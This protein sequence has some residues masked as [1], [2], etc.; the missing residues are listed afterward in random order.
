MDPL[1]LDTTNFPFHKNCFSVLPSP[2]TFGLGSS[3]TSLSTDYTS[4][5]FDYDI[6][7]SYDYAYDPPSPANS[8]PS[9]TSGSSPSVTTSGSDR[10][11]SPASSVH[12]TP[13]ASPLVMD[14]KPLV[15]HGGDH[16]QFDNG[17]INFG[18]EEATAAHAF[19]E[20]MDF[21]RSTLDLDSLSSLAR[22]SD[23]DMYRPSDG[24]MYQHHAQTTSTQPVHLYSQLP[25][26][27]P[28]PA[29]FGNSAIYL[30]PPQVAEPQHSYY[31]QSN[32]VYLGSE[33]QAQQVLQQPQPAVPL[34]YVPA[35]APVQ[36]SAQLININGMTYAVAMPVA[37]PAP[38]AIETPHG[39]YYFVPNAQPQPQAQ[40]PVMSSSVASESFVLSSGL[41]A[42]VAASIPG[43]SPLS[44]PAP[45]PQP[46]PRSVV[47]SSA[48]PHDEATPV[49]SD[50]KI[51]LPVGQGKR[52][53]TKRQPKKDQV[54]RFVC[55]FSGCGRGFARNFNMQSHYKSHLGV[56]EFNCSHCPKKFSRRH[57][58]ARHC[59]AVHDSHVDRDGNIL[60]SASAAGSATASPSSSHDL[61]L[62]HDEHDEL[63]LDTSLD[64]L[65]SSVGSSSGIC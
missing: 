25:S 37:A 38:A 48:A 22:P 16:A 61:V 18:S 5:A 28:S 19:K 11:V 40:Q 14:I 9:L 45:V 51:R 15:L 60:G 31:A 1:Q 13:T 12:L 30:Q 4:T 41:P 17:S 47:K 53:S 49:D 6:P 21:P 55:P 52:G 34:Q 65:R 63:D 2:S 10:A 64:Q 23:G 46:A 3:Y 33:Q 54:K 43:F 29:S 56:R 39:T 7:T 57:D 50:Q 20:Q 26:P 35:P 8:V 42:P 24:D 44:M 62:E 36:P 27:A 32:S 58:R 59:A